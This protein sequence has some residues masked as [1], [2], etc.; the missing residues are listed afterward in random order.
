MDGDSGLQ[1]AVLSLL[2]NHY[3]E[4]VLVGE[5]LENLD[6]DDRQLTRMLFS[7]HEDGYIEAVIGEA[8]P[9][10]F[11]AG[12]TITTKGQ[13]LL[14]GETDF[15]TVK[16]HEDTIEELRGLLLDVISQTTL[17]AEQKGLLKKAIESAQSA[18]IT[19]SVKMILAAG[20]QK[21]PELLNQIQESLSRL[22]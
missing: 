13:R 12:A 22:V 18:A 15:I 14:R 10:R 16:L 11:V 20:I 1:R 4:L 2:D 8:M 17:P 7:L 19:E 21:V 9:E 5:L 6:C 3:P